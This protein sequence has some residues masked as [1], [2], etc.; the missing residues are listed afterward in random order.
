MDHMKRGRWIKYAGFI[1]AATLTVPCLSVYALIPEESDTVLEETVITAEEVPEIYMESVED[2]D[3]SAET[4]DQDD[5][6]E[7]FEDPA[8]TGIVPE[9]T[10]DYVPVFAEE[11]FPAEGDG[12]VTEYTI[13]YV[14]NGPETGWD[15]VTNP[16]G[17]PGTYTGRS[18]IKLKKAIRKGYKFG[19]WYKDAKFKKKVTQIKKGSRGNRTLYAK[20]IENKYTVILKANGGKGKTKKLR[21]SASKALMLPVCPFTYSGHTFRCWSTTQIA[22]TDAGEYGPEAEI[23]PGT[24]TEKGR[25]VTLYAQWDNNNA[26]DLYVSGAGDDSNDGSKSAPFKTI[27]HAI[28]SSATGSTI[29]VAAGTYDETLTFTKSGELSDPITICGETTVKTGETE[30][31]LSCPSKLTYTGTDE[32]ITLIDINGCSN[33]RVENLDIGNVSTKYACGIY[34]PANSKNITIQ[35]CRI[36]DIKVAGQ[37]L[38]SPEDNEENAGEANA[39]LC[40][41]EGTTK[42]KAINNILIRDNEVC[43]NV[44]NWSESVSAA[45]NVSNVRVIGNQVHDNTNIGIDFNGNTGYCKKANLDQ[46]RNCEARGNTVYNCHCEYAECAGIYV[47]GA[48]STKLTG[49]VVHDCDYGIEVGAEIKKNK[50]PVKNITVDGNNIHDNENGGIWIGGYDEKNSGT[51]KKT[52]ITNNVLKDN[53]RGEGSAEIV[54]NRCS[55]ITF[56]GNIIENT[57]P[58]ETAGPLIAGEMGSK[59]TSELK[60]KGNLYR[61]KLSPDQVRF[62]LYGKQITGIKAFNKKTK[63]SDRAEEII[64]E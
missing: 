51:V 64:N 1:T 59:Y 37:Y 23:A 29:H 62:V 27:Q 38:V 44:T 35:N 52:K 18:T 49:N 45:G 8:E 19:G 12:E 46:P 47:D 28:D 33:I 34:I 53:C 9:E 40:F 55:G 61:T 26:V 16:E 32:N 13:D 22:Y 3:I 6:A 39:I 43:G 21:G 14:L 50:Y 15:A 10:G 24:Y 30:W 2:T 42:A 56:K 60:F 17:N 31:S 58:V 41:G 11:E 25:K 20:W 36:H 4:G 48:K 54:I 57:T 63:G 5:P 7:T